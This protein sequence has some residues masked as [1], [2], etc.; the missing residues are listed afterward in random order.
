MGLR[1][2][3]LPCVFFSV[4]YLESAPGDSSPY[5]IVEVK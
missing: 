4:E 2:E 5:A 1:T 3:I